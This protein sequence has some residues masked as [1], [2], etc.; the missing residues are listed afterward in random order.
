MT[1]ID[2]QNN[3]F[4]EFGP[5]RLDLTQRILL[6]EG[7]QVPL[8]LKA[9]EPLL[10]LVENCGRILEKEELLNHVWPDTFI[11]EATLAKNVSTLR[12]ALA[13]GN[14]TQE[15]I[16]TIPRRG[17]RFVAEVK[18]V[19]S[20]MEEVIVVAVSADHNREKT[21]TES[22]G[23]M[24]TTARRTSANLG[25]SPR[26]SPKKGNFFALTTIIVRVMGAIFGI[27]K[28]SLD[29]RPTPKPLKAFQAMKVMRITNSGKAVDAAI[30][31]DGRYVA[32]VVEDTGQKSLWG[33]QVATTTNIQI[34]AATEA[35]FYG[36]T[37]SPDGSHIY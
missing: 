1:R 25:A 17:Y 21:K 37:F 9:Y 4:Y 30:S 14:G 34:L 3:R 16:E 12:L 22:V 35:R 8:T 28:F 19:R 26:T 18:E 13:E 36:L 31:P 24:A 5:F 7:Q 15:Y 2:K 20:A 29:K 6:R 27:Y 23:Q 10:V 32:Y 33:R 11:E